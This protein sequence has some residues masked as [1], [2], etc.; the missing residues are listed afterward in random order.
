MVLSLRVGTEK[1]NS[2]LHVLVGDGEAQHFRV[3]AP[4]L[5]QI[6]TKQSH[7]SQA[8]NL[9]HTGSLPPTCLDNTMFS[10]TVDGSTT[11]ALSTVPQAWRTLPPYRRPSARQSWCVNTTDVGPCQAKFVAASPKTSPRSPY[12]GAPNGTSPHRGIKGR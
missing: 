5:H 7:V 10:T 2:P 6:V 12:D 3:K 9:W 1:D 8:A 4:H 11:G